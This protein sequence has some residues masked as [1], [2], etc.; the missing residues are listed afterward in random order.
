MRL[1]CIASRKPLTS[2]DNSGKIMFKNVDEN[3]VNTIVKTWHKA[4]LNIARRQN[5]KSSQDFGCSG[6]VFRVKEWKCSK[7]K[8]FM[9]K[10]GISH[11][12]SKASG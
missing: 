2:K 7:D 1:P 12:K 9:K 4:V 3:V 11:R 6:E 10:R 8:K 5:S